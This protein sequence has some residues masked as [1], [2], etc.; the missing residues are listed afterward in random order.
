MMLGGAAVDS[1]LP[2]MA[3][4]VAVPYDEAEH[5]TLP[6]PTALRASPASTHV[7]ETESVNSDA[8][9]PPSPLAAEQY[10]SEEY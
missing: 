10:D 9:I 5:G 1:L 6:L 8:T 7:D 3:T 2:L 4:A